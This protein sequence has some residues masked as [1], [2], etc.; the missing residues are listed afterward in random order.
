M[1]PKMIQ[2][3]QDYWCEYCPHVDPE[4]GLDI[5]VDEGRGLI[6]LRQLA[7]HVHEKHPE[8]ANDET[9]R[10]MVESVL[11][12]AEQFIEEN[13]T[14]TIEEVRS[15]KVDENPFWLNWNEEVETVASRLERDRANLRYRIRDERNA[16]NREYFEELAERYVEH[17]L[18][19]APNHRSVRVGLCSARAMA[20]EAEQELGYQIDSEWMCFDYLAEA[21]PE[22]HPDHEPSPRKIKTK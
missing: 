1:E 19:E 3:K 21:L 15:K 10:E 9:P 4:E 8:Q 18:S 14:P 2:K 17:W 7:E 16:L 6:S 22:D 5:P 11:G 20:Y 12:D 13:I